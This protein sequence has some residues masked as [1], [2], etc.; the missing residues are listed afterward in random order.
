MRRSAPSKN[1]LASRLADCVK[2]LKISLPAALTISVTLFL[3]RVSTLQP[4]GRFQDLR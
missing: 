2:R 3:E 4:P 1:D